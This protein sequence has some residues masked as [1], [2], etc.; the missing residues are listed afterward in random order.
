VICVEDNGCGFDASVSSMGNGLGNQQ[1][2]LKRVG[3]TV[4][5]VSRVGDGTRI[6]FRV[7]LKGGG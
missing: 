6:I 2:R 3:G 1:T 7:S 5:L 4:E